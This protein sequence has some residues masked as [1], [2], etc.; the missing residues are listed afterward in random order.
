MPLFRCSSLATTWQSVFRISTVGYGTRCLL[1]ASFIDAASAIRIPSPQHIA[2]VCVS[3]LV[4]FHMYKSQ[5]HGVQ[6]GLIQRESPLWMDRARAGS[7]EA[8]YESRDHGCQAWFFSV[9][10][11]MN[12]L[13]VKVPSRPDGGEEVVKRTG[14]VHEGVFKTGFRRWSLLR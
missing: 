3:P 8:A 1:I 5:D 10:S 14:T 9:P 13:R 11:M 12:S 6:H 4:A 2:D 7:R